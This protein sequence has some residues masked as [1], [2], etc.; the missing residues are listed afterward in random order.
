MGGRPLALVGL[1]GLGV[2][3]LAMAAGNYLVVGPNFFVVVQ[4]VVVVA[5]GFLLVR[6]RGDEAM[7]T[8]EDPGLSPPV[9]RY[10][11]WALAALG[12]LTLAVGLLT[13]AVALA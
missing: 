8:F 7:L 11:P 4:A 10:A 2:G 1:G 12:T 6:A 9:R 5:V 13:L 3:S